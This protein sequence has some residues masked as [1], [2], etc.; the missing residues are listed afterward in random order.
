MKRWPS[1]GFAFTMVFVIMFIAS[2]ISMTYADTDELIKLDE[3][4]RS[5]KGNIKLENTELSAKIEKF[6]GLMKKGKKKK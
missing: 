1:F 4:E 2:M 6:L 5:G 3:W